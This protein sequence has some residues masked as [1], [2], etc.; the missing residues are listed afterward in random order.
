MYYLLYGFLYLVSLLPFW[1]LYGISHFAFVLIYHIIGY[2]KEIVMSNLAIAFPYKTVEERKLIARKFYRN[3]TDNFIET[4]KLLSISPKRLHQHFTWNYDK[5]NKYYATG[6]NIQLHLGHFF[7]WEYAALSASLGSAFPVLV[8]Y[9]PIAGK[10]MNKVFLKLRSRFGAKMIPA[11]TFIKD[12]R[13]YTRSRYCLVFVAD[14]NA[15]NFTAAYWLPFFGKMAPFVTGPEKSARLNNT[16]CMY[17]EFTK[18]KRGHYYADFVEMTEEPRQL[19]EG[20]LTK[21]LIGLIEDNLA[22]QP[23]NYLWT[24]RRWK[25][26]YDPSKHKTF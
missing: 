22:K 8:V 20:E 4:I 5:L 13:A 26:T 6:R 11:N 18:I 3:F 21:K 14:Q 25:H 19:K 7:N 12:F 15:G 23:S 17:V 16:V 10:A 2:R 1:I 24:H 9:M